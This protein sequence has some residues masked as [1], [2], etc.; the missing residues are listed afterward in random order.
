V[1]LAAY[2]T[3]A[4]H[5]ELHRRGT[6]GVLARTGPDVSIWCLTCGSAIFLFHRHRSRTASRCPA[7]T[8]RQRL[9]A[10]LC[11]KYVPQSSP[12]PAPGAF[13]SGIAIVWAVQCCT[14][15]AATSP[16]A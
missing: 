14:A 5:A 6:G 13:E 8:D 1:R 7:G 2:E 9:T 15:S 4:L 12:S 16:S 11:P 3:A 10:A